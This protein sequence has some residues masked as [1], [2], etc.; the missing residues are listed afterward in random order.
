MPGQVTTGDQL[1]SVITL[2]GGL[3]DEEDCDKVTPCRRLKESLSSNTAFQRNYLEMC[4][5]A[6]SSFK[7]IGRLR[8]AR[9]V[10]RDLASFYI[11]MGEHV[12]AA[13][14]LV[15]ALKTFQQEKW[16]LLSLQTMLDLVTCYT[17][18][19]DR[20]RLARMCAQIASCDAATA[21]V[22]HKYFQQFQAAMKDLEKEENLIMPSED[23]FNFTSCSIIEQSHDQIIPGDTITFDLVLYNNLPGSIKCDGIKVAVVFVDKEKKDEDKVDGAMMSSARKPVARSPSSVSTNSSQVDIN[24]DTIDTTDVTNGDD[25]QLDIVEQLDY[26]QDKSLCSARLVCRNTLKV[27]KRKDSSGSMLRDLSQ[28]QKSDYQFSLSADSVTLSPGV[29]NVKVET[30]AGA[31]GQYTMTQMSVMIQ[32]VEFLYDITGTCPLYQ[33]IMC[34][35][36]ISVN[37][38]V[39]QL[40][41]GLDNDLILTVSTGSQVVKAGTKIKIQASKGLKLRNDESQYYSDNIEVSLDGGEAYQTIEAKFQVKC[42][43]SNQ[44]DTSTIEHK[45]IISDPWSGKTK[46]AFI[47]FIPAFYTTFNLLTA[48]DKKFLQIFVFPFGDNCFVLSRHQLTLSDTCQE[49]SLTPINNDDDILVS[50]SNCEAGYL[51]QLNIPQA[52][53]EELI[54]KVVKAKFSL[55]YKERT[56]QNKEN[57][58]YEANFQFQNFLTLYTIQAK[59]EQPKTKG[60]EFCRAGAMCPMTIQLEQCNTSPYNNLYYEVFV[61]HYIKVGL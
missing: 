43:L 40:F 39:R 18:M 46:D 37:K 60:G 47:H 12:K 19:A 41:A 30:V 3:P 14:F 15:E 22:R 25:D 49:L 9:L 1:H 42:N 4:E 21:E 57:E 7:H 29:N 44:K 58:I 28:Q 35:P 23:V 53:S 11:Q 13:T 33:V 59:V 5:I 26:K 52:V 32:G 54:N 20:E 34:P 16:S 51:W 2:T 31:E 36:V 24:L 50:D 10:G 6:I 61:R 17:A 27:L 45:L 56:K 48:M 55:E 38:D 8:S